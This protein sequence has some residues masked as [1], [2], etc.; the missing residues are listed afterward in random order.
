MSDLSERALIEAGPFPPGY[1]PA[2]TPA[3]L[4]IALATGCTAPAPPGQPPLWDSG[5]AP[6]RPAELPTRLLDDD[7]VLVVP[8]SDGLAIHRTDGTRARLMI[9]S[10]IAPDCN[11]C[12]GEGA[13][14]D[15]DGLLVTWSELS[16]GR[17]VELQGGLARLAFDGTPT[18]GPR[19]L[20]FPH[21]A[22]R[23]PSDG[24]IAVAEAFA[25]RVAWY[26]DGDTSGHPIAVLGPREHLDV[27]LTNGLDHLAWQGR[28]LVA[29]TG[30]GNL[31]NDPSGGVI[32]LWDLTDPTVPQRLWRFPE[33][34]GLDSP[35]GGSLRWYDGQW[36]L[37]YAHTFAVGDVGTI[38]VA[39][40]ADPTEPPSYVADLVPA[41]V[42]PLWFV[43]GVDLTDDGVL[44]ITDS[45]LDLSGKIGRILAAP[46][47]TLPPAATSGAAPDDQVFA[48]LED[49]ELLATDIPNP[50]EGWLWR[51]PAESWFT[52]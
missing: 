10:D 16:F 22:V 39:T 5:T 6:E 35:H 50:F 3:A 45:G 44:L 51:A 37:L 19:E 36:W 18:L 4:L 28:H 23:Q 12:V 38:G 21:D 31:Q 41:G 48:L 52:P 17:A 42:D 20:A 11:G 14:A 13:S 33:S 26:T 30:R 7:H 47:P 15:G 32:E 49:V 1:A 40:M 27:P 2:V 9:W 46:F 29:I 25:D 34:G 8:Q 24:S 43:R